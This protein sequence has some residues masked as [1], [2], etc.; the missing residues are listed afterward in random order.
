M[1]FPW[2]S[3]SAKTNAENLNNAKAL[4]KAW[5]KLINRSAWRLD[6]AKSE[7]REYDAVRIEALKAKKQIHFGR[8]FDFVD[9]KQSNLH[10]E[11]WV[12]KGRVVFIGNRVADQSGFGA[13]FVKQGSSSSQLTAA[14][15]LD[16]ISH[17]RGMEVENQGRRVLIFK[18]QWKASAFGT[19][20]HY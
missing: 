7:V 20:D 8:T 1:S 10:M 14:N 12:P 15:L 6:P 16:A 18:I 4:S 9:I 5:P 11:N 2:H 3:S 17:M 13:L 19:M